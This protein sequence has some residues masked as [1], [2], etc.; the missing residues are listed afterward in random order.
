MNASGRAAPLLVPIDEHEMVDPE[1][2]MTFVRSRLAAFN[3]ANSDQA[4]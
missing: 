2:E 3:R 4:V 1:W